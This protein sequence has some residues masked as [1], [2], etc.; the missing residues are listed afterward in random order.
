MRTFDVIV[1][2]ENGAYRA[3]VPSLPNILAEGTSRDEAVKKVKE[4]IENFFTTAEVTT[5]SVDVPADEFRP[6]STARDWLRQAALY[7]EPDDEMARH[8]EEIYAERKRP[9]EAVERELE[10]ADELSAP[11]LQF[12]PGSPKA[13]LKAAAD[14]RI[15]S[16]DELYQQYLADMEF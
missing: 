4:A 7:S 9:R 16:G 3:F 15:D 6:Y 1:Q 11:D 5:V 2:R 8:I 12:P 13:V 14:C 10:I